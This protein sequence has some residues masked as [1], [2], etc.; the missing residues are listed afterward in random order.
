MWYFCFLK[1]RTGV[2]NFTERKTDY[3]FK[4]FSK[5]KFPGKISDC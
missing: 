4:Y 2:V 3:F 5:T 1:I